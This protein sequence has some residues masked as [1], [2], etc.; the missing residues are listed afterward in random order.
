M[1]SSSESLGS[2]GR[3]S[4]IPSS[5]WRGRN[6]TDDA[7]TSSRPVS[8]SNSIKPTRALLR[9]GSANTRGSSRRMS[10]RT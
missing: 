3:V 5:A 6:R 10:R 8:S 7:P 9:R 2:N 4:T 1:V